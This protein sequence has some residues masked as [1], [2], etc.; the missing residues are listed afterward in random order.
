M[1]EFWM[2][3]TQDGSGLVLKSDLDSSVSNSTLSQQVTTLSQQ[4]ATLTQELNQLI[5][6]IVNITYNSTINLQP[7]QVLNAMMVVS[8][9]IFQVCLLTMPSVSSLVS[10]DTN[11]AIGKGYYV[12]VINNG[13][14]ESSAQF[15]Y[16]G[17]FTLIGNNYVGGNS[18]GRFYFAYTNIT[19]GQQAI[20]I[21]RV[22]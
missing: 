17:G 1:T 6:V 12:T 18:S 19:S 3:K 21:Y 11:A 13:N 8:V 5:P 4:V 10:Y 20:T 14:P 7:N 2:T 9:P 22:S 15:S 16:G